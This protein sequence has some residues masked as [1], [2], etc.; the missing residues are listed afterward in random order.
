MNLSEE[1]YQRQMFGEIDGCYPTENVSRARD[2]LEKFPHADYSPT[3]SEENSHDHG[4]AAEAQAQ[5]HASDIRQD[6]DAFA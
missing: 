1:I 4:S 3:Y 5:D 2:V 6:C